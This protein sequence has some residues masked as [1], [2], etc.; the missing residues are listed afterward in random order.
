MLAPSLHLADTCLGL[1]Q[2]VIVLLPHLRICLLMG[3][4]QCCAHQ[5]CVL[6]ELG[7]RHRVDT[8]GLCI[9]IG[10]LGRF[11]Q[12]L[13]ISIE[14]FLQGLICRCGFLPGCAHLVHLLGG[15]GYGLA[16]GRG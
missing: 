13:G 6:L 9:L 16:Q 1:L 4:G 2:F 10:V 7:E 11:L 12:S 5:L 3:V 8:E 15:V 14:G